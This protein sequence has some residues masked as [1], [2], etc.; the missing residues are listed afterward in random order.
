MRRIVYLH[1]FASGPTSRKAQF[2]R[3]KLAAKGLVLELPDLTEGDFEHLTMARQLAMLERL[4]GG[5]S[6]T[7]IGS[8]LGG[9]L[10]ALYASRHPE[11]ERLVLLAPAFAFSERWEALVG[12]EAMAR[13]RATRKLPVYHYGEDR[14]RE[15]DF[16][17]V[18]EKCEAYPMFSQPCRIYH[19]RADTV[20]PC[21]Y[22]ERFT[23]SHANAPLTLLET[24]HGMVDALPDIWRDAGDFLTS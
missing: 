21:E 9:Y 15:L 20:V 24:D 18:E 2:F 8:S 13:W 17:I 3:E 5:R 12:P 6:L 10:A 19:G 1:G 22:S 7:L 16:G 23:A 4:G 11:T 14:E